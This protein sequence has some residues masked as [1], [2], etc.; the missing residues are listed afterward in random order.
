MLSENNSQPVESSSGSTPATAPAVVETQ[1][2]FSPVIS[3]VEVVLTLSSDAESSVPVLVREN[4]EGDLWNDRGRPGI[5][6]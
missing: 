1:P 3:T 4:A 2:V 6:F 5:G